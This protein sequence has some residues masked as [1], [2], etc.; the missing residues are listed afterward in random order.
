M[1]YSGAL[2]SLAAAPGLQAAH[3]DGEAFFD[4]QFPPYTYAPDQRREGAWVKRRY[5][6]LRDQIYSRWVGLIDVGEQD[7]YVLDIHRARG[8]NEHW[9]SFHGPCGEA[10]VDGLDNLEAWP[11]GSPA[12]KE[13]G[14]GETDK[15]NGDDASRHSLTYLYDCRRSEVTRPWKATWRLSGNSN[16][17][18]RMRQLAADGE[19]IL[20]RGKPP[21]SSMENPPYELTW[22]LAH[23]R[24]SA[25]LSSQFVSTIEASEAGGEILKRVERVPARG[26]G[27]FEPVA[28]RATTAEWTDLVVNT[29]QGGPVTPESDDWSFEGQYGFARSGKSGVEQVS[30]TGGR[31]FV[32]RDVG[33]VETTG[34]LTAE[35][36]GGDFDKRQVV[37]AGITERPEALVGHHVRFDSENRSSTYRVLAASAAA[38]GV[39]LSL[40]V[41]LRIGAGTADGFEQGAIISHTHFPLAGFRYYQG[42]RLQAAGGSSFVVDHIESEVVAQTDS[43]FQ[44]RSWIVLESGDGREVDPQRL[45]KACGQ[46][47]SFVIYDVGAGDRATF[48]LTSYV[49]RV[50]VATWEGYI[51]PKTVLALGK[52]PSG[53]A[54]VVR[55][56]RR[57]DLP[58]REVESGL[59]TVDLGG[60]GIGMGQVEISLC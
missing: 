10:V 59:S 30:L 60:A 2:R 31:R 53:T 17:E 33:V 41:D 18:L 12:G 47:G 4:L 23:R 28:V 57:W 37:L 49:R 45:S 11:D 14:Y 54:Q 22:T 58:V 50:D 29:A 9:W 26:T 15:A 52:V 25:P 21:I 48:T 32:A 13:I 56:D 27:A 6:V 42:A 39:C 44:P 36:L 3:A 8:G 46:G 55:G 35:V 34:T 38:E 24:G 40:D 7:F 16:L 19:V 20:G 51:G 43:G 1:F 5:Q